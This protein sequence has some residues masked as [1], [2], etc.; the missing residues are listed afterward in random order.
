MF[1]QFELEVTA[2]DLKSVQVFKADCSLNLSHRASTTAGVRVK[3]EAWKEIMIWNCLIQRWNTVSWLIPVFYK[4]DLQNQILIFSLRTILDNINKHFSNFSLRELNVH[5][6]KRW[7][8]APGNGQTPETGRSID[9]S[10]VCFICLHDIGK[11]TLQYLFF[12]RCILCLCFPS[13]N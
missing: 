6:L 3:N 11:I 10:P 13:I 2:E 4:S 9:G 1:V 12:L 7:L 8:S 5:E